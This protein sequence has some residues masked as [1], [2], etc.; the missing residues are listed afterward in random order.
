MSCHG[1][2]RL[3]IKI[4][5]DKNSVRQKEILEVQATDSEVSLLVIPTDEEHEI[6]SQTLDVIRNL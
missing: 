3:G 1:M 4:D 6:A 2:E 5:P